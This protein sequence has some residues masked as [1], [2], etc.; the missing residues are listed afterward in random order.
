MRMKAGLE[1]RVPLSPRA[2]AIVRE[3]A[4]TKVSDFVFPG[5]EV[6]RP[7]ANGKG[8]PPKERGLSNMAMTLVMRRMKVDATVHGFRSA[9]R[10]WAA[11]TIKIVPTRRA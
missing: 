6:L 2:L 10:D 5:Q 9:F 8:V 1:H 3:M 4:E 7:C 11:N